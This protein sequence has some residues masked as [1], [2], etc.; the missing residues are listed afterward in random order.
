VREFPAFQEV[1][2]KRQG[3]FELISVAVDERAN[4]RSVVNQGGYTW[5]FALSDTAAQSYGF[6]AI[7]TT[8][9]ID[10][11]GNVVEQHTGGMSATEFEMRL[12]KIL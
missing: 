10:S 11:A 7:P 6:S 12:S 2:S 3:E 4:P 1:Y 9:F 5:I 8:L